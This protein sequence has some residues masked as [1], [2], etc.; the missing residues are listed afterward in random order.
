MAGVEGVPAAAEIDLEPGA[1]IHRLRLGRHAD[2]AEIAGAVARRD[3]HAAAQRDREVREVAAHAAAL[4]E[5]VAWRCASRAHADSRSATWECTKSQIAWTRAQPSGVLPNSDQASVIEPLGLAVAAAEQEHQRVVRQSP[6]SCWR[7]LGSTA[8]GRP[9]SAT[10]ASVE[11]SIWPGRRH[12][13][14][15]DVAE[16]IEIARDGNAAAKSATDPA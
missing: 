6:T 16:R 15:A 1:E 13:T 4:D 14:A 2:V 12:Q 3:V 9:E 10:I 11:I 7:A 8:S 5:G